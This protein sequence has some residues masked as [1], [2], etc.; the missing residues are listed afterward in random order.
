MLKQLFIRWSKKKQVKNKKLLEKGNQN[1]NI[2]NSNF[3]VPLSTIL[4]DNLTRIKAAFGASS[5]LVVREIEIGTEHP[6]QAVVIFI[7]G[8]TGD[9]LVNENVVGPLM[10]GFGAAGDSKPKVGADPFEIIK[11]RLLIVGEV[12]EASFLGEVITS[13][14]NGNC[15]IIIENSSRALIASTKGW[16]QRNIEEPATESLIRGPRE[17][18]IEHLRPNTALLRLRI[19]N[20]ELR[21]EEMQIGEITGTTVALA[22]VNNIASPKVVDEVRN[23]LKR[24]RTDAILESGYLEEFIEDTPL[25]PFPQLIR[26]ERPD[27][28]AAGLLEGKIAIFT[29]GSPFVLLVPAFLTE[30]LTTPEDYYE[31]FVI[32]TFV[33]LIRYGAFVISLILP[34][35]YVAI[36]TYHQEMLPTA[37]VISIANQREG[38]PFPAFV[39]AFLLE[40]IIEVV[41]EASL[42]MPRL[43]GQTLTIVGVLIIGQSAVQAGLFSNIMLVVV[44]L[45]A[46]ASF[47]TPV[48]SVGITLRLLRFVLLFLA[49]SLGI[50]GIVAGIYA[51]YLHLVSL[52]SFGFPY[53]KPLAP[54]VTSDLKDT[55]IRVPRWAMRTRPRL[56]GFQDSIRQTAGLKPA[57]PEQRTK[58]KAKRR[59]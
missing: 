53:L 14:V 34:A 47:T 40:L 30:L 11:K 33:R 51:L 49:A 12:T 1:V 4:K 25:S 21:I 59:R 29:E 16:K 54:L 20:P 37:I 36:I 26:T 13:I 58:G 46:I 55:A 18:F 24:I 35:L 38:I 52:R 23:R 19:K 50:F 42:R 8:I 57:P 48:F 56:T 41:R 6:L 15:A 17:G 5:D 3:D 28:A 27:K 7:D 10:A 45:T 2:L 22:Y 39:E 44:A 43:I 9:I 31:R 32:S